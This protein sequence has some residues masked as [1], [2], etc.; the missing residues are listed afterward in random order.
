MSMPKM[1]LP[2]RPI[3]CALLTLGQ[4]LFLIAPVQAQ[5]YPN[6]IP[7][8]GTGGYYNGMG[9]S[10]PMMGYQPFT[11]GPQYGYAARSYG[12]LPSQGLGMAVGLG[13]VGGMVGIGAVMMGSRMLANRKMNQNNPNNP[14]T[15]QPKDKKGAA[16]R[17]R[18]QEL[19]I[20]GELDQDYQKDLADKGLVAQTP[21]MPGNANSFGGQSMGGQPFAGS[22]PAQS[23]GQ[24]P[25]S[26]AM[27][28]AGMTPPPGE[29][30]MPSNVPWTP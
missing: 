10:N 22:A 17:R 16:Q 9:L 8:P 15:G 25:F 27:S 7:S 11:T 26:P 13:Y 2:S 6:F 14:N 21:Q 3:I 23:F 18:D 5:G 19:K 4:T 20:K 28:P 29:T 30:A 12:S 24:A 1:P